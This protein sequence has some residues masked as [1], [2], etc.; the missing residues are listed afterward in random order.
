M[1]TATA[2]AHATP[3]AD[4]GRYLAP[5]WA[6]RNLANPLVIRL[7]RSGLSPRGARELQVRGRRS[8]EWRGVPVN[9]LQLGDGRYL[10]APRGETDWVRN[11][12]AAGKGRLRRGR[13]VAEFTARELAGAEKIPVIRAYLSAWAFEVGKFFEGITIDSTDDEIRSI[14]DG[15]P[16]FAITE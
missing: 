15:F 7:V 13:H 5:D 4:E 8:G 3:T 16:V 1:N 14:V 2:A 12:R 6:T 11:L 9:P 10:V